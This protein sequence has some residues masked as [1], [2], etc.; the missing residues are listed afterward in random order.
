M[1]VRLVPIIQLQTHVKSSM[2]IFPPNRFHFAT[3][4]DK[5]RWARQVEEKREKDLKRKTRERMDPVW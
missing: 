4:E 2:T 1:N 5:E 3:S